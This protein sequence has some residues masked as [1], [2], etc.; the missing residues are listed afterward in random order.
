L[1]LAVL[2]GKPEA[3]RGTFKNREYQVRA[4]RQGIRSFL[5]TG[6]F[7]R[8]AKLPSPKPK[9]KGQPANER[10]LT[11]DFSADRPLSDLFE[12]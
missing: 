7:Y 5:A 12:D 6:E 1:P 11:F 8:P 2:R 10:Q 9:K 3:V 4:T